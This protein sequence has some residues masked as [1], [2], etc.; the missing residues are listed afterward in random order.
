MVRKVS[1]HLFDISWPAN[2]SMNLS[3]AIDGFNALQ[4]AARARDDIRLDEAVPFSVGQNNFYYLNFSKKRE[5]GPGKIGSNSVVQG[6][7]LGNGFHFGE[8]TTALY[9]QT[10]NVMLVLYNHYGVG[11]NRMMEYFNAYDPGNTACFLDFNGSP[12]LNAA[13]HAQFKR[14]KHIDRVEVTATIDALAEDQHAEGVALARASKGFGARRVSF[15]LNANDFYKKGDYLKKSPVRSFLKKMMSK[16]DDE[17]SVLRVKGLVGERDKLIDLI[18]Q[19]MSAQFNET[20]LQVQHNKYTLQSKKD[21][22]MR[23]HNGWKN[24]I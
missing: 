23:C 6:V 20:D 2:N 13:A 11:I 5:I 3:Q 4:L 24:I 1:V 15:S 7:N 22:L 17:V 18:E 8:E 9:D 14:M 16:S 12:R 21:L 19:K 10:K